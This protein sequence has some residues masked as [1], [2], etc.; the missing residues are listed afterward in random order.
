MRNKFSTFTILSVINILNLTSPVL[1]HT[2]DE[3]FSGCWGGMGGMMGSYG[4]GFFGWIFSTLVVVALIL[5]IAWLIKQ[6]QKK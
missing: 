5:L 3:N 1:A 4:M 6:I 2:G